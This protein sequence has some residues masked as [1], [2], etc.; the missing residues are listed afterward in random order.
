MGAASLAGSDWAPRPWKGAA[1]G[2]LCVDG[3]LVQ[4]QGPAGKLP[5]RES[6]GASPL[7]HQDIRG[8]GADRERPAP[9]GCLDGCSEQAAHTLQRPHSPGAALGGMGDL[10]SRVDRPTDPGLGLW[11]LLEVWVLVPSDCRV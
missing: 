1:Q 3:L 9:P 8:T 5:G 2:R 10:A 11:S 7:S 4:D 6:E